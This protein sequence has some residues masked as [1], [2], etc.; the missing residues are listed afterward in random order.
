[1]LH[2]KDFDKLHKTLLPQRNG[3]VFSDGDIDD[4]NADRL[5]LFLVYDGKSDVTETVVLVIKQKK[6][7]SLILTLF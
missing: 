2:I 4:M 7:C 3:G 1:M 6:G 5:S